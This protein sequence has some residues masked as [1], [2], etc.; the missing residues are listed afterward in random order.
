MHFL[1]RGLFP[2]IDGAALFRLIACRHRKRNQI[3]AILGD[4]RVARVKPVADDQC[5][6]ALDR[7]V[8][9][10]QRVFVNDFTKLSVPEIGRFAWIRPPV[11]RVRVHKLPLGELTRGVQSQLQSPLLSR[12]SRT[13]TWSDHA[14]PPLT[15]R[16]AVFGNSVAINSLVFST[17]C[18][19]TCQAMIRRPIGIHR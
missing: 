6:A 4:H 17:M 2:R 9:L 15:R 14:A 1:A 18:A 11:S 8:D 16:I 12:N 5:R 13:A 3:V 7:A 19:K 10:T